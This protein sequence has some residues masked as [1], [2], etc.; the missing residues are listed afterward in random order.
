MVRELS[1]VLVA[2]VGPPIWAKRTI[3][4]SQTIVWKF[5]DFSIT[6]I[7]CEIIFEESRS[8]KTAVSAILGGLN[9]V[10]FD[11]FHFSLQK[12]MKTTIQSL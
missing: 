4:S 8:S 5:K 1:M 10:K 6:R 2:H 3:L 12:F 7:L 11:K 9:L